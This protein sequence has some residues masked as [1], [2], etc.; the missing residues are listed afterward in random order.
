MDDSSLI[1]LSL[2]EML[3]KLVMFIDLFDEHNIT[4][5]TRSRLFAVQPIKG[6]GY[7]MVTTQ[8]IDAF[9]VIL[10][11]KPLLIEPMQLN[12]SLEN[13]LYHQ[14]SNLNQSQQSLILNLSNCTPTKDA[15]QYENDAQLLLKRNIHGIY[16]TNCVGTTDSLESNS[17]LFPTFA[18]INHSC[19]PNCCMYFEGAPTNCIVLKSLFPIAKGVEITIGYIPR[20]LHT[21]QERQQ[22]LQTSYGF[23]CT[24]TELCSLDTKYDSLIVEYRECIKKRKDLASIQRAIDILNNHFDGY[25]SIAPHLYNICADICIDAKMYDDA[26]HYIQK[27]I[28]AHLKCFSIYKRD[29]WKLIETKI[30]LIQHKS[31]GHSSADVILQKYKYLW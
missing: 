5:Q 14:F 27:S 13:E 24:C 25:P 8:N 10:L 22:I 26:I 19:L 15:K 29:R 23:R 12:T 4:R 30:R 31:H 21:L 7:G 2:K 28:T 9:T 16:H 11:E 3:D 6:K 20:L 18:K 1:L 17:A